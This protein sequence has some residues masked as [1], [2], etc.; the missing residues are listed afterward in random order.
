MVAIPI[1][2]SRPRL[3]LRLQPYIS[4]VHHHFVYGVLILLE[5]LITFVVLEL[6]LTKGF[7]TKEVNNACYL[8]AMFV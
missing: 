5:A 3:L 8:H 4:A 1:V 7:C 2:N 6:Q